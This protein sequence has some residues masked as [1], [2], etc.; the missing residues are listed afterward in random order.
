MIKRNEFR[1]LKGVSS[2]KREDVDENATA[3]PK[4]VVAGLRSMVDVLARAHANDPSDETL[5]ALNEGL[6]KYWAILL[7]VYPHRFPKGAYSFSLENEIRLIAIEFGFEEVEVTN[8][9]K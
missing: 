7:E 6:D 5:E 4:V 8:V 2:I 1:A 9:E 3:P